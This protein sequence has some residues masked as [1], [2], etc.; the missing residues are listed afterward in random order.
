MMSYCQ[1]TV[2]KKKFYRKFR[3]INNRKMN[4]SMKLVKV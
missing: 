3:I 2:I 1:T 4:K